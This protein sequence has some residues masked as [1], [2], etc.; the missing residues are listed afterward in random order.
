M[1]D[2]LKEILVGKPGKIIQVSWGIRKEANFE[3]VKKVFTEWNYL[4]PAVITKVSKYD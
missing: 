4:K 1:N 3:D 2:T